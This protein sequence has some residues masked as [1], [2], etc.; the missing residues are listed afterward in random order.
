MTDNSVLGFNE[1]LELLDKKVKELEK[2]IQELEARSPV[3]DHTTTQELIVY[4]NKENDEMRYLTWTEDD[5][6]EKKKKFKEHRRFVIGRI[7]KT[8]K[9]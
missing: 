6:P 8:N 5:S 3:I 7:L 1:K 4:R 2:T 9:D